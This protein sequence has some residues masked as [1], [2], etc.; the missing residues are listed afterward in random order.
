[1]EM[2]KALQSHVEIQ[3]YVGDLTSEEFVEN[4][5]DKCIILFGELNYA[6]HAAGIFG[7]AEATDEMDYAE[8]CKVQRANLDSIWFCERAELKTM[9][10]QNS[11]DGYYPDYET[12]YRIDEN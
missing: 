10:K 8:Y 9:L 2:A 3:S 11:I 6:V 4:V 12:G 1:M 7:K 5:V